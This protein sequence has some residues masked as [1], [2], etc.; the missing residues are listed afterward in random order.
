MKRTPITYEVNDDCR[1]CVHV[2]NERRVPLVI[3]QAPYEVE[4]SGWG[5]FEVQITLFF[6]DPNEKPVRVTMNTNECIAAFRS[7]SI[8]I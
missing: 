2:Q 1:T 8:I 5:E 6:T 4:E 3:S 7:P